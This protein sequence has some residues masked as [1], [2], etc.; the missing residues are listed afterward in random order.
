M[1]AGDSK[2]LA[3][4][5]VQASHSALLTSVTGNRLPCNNWPSLWESWSLISRPL[6]A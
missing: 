2:R 4:S 3:A 1:L 5:K 6:S